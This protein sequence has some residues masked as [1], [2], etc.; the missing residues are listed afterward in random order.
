MLQINKRAPLSGDDTQKLAAPFLE[1]LNNSVR[2]IRR[3]SD[4]LGYYILL[5]AL[6]VLYLVMTPPKFTATG[7]MVIDTRKVQ[8]LQQQQSVLGDIQI[9]AATVQTSSGG[10]EIGQC[11]LGGDT[12]TS[13]GRRSGICSSRHRGDERSF[14][15]SVSRRV[16]EADVRVRARANR[17]DRLPEP[18]HGYSRRSDLC[19]RISIFTSLNAE[20]SARIVNT[21][22]EAFVEAN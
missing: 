11:R 9:D 10:V 19:H 12:K 20:K 6:A 17:F 15:F 13:F 22:V 18:P 14:Q 5:S 1:A 21:L 8:I 2:I 7:S 3:T 16:N 4:R